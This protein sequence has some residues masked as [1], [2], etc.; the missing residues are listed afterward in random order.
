MS[1]IPYE[2]QFKHIEGGEYEFRKSLFHLCYVAL[3]ACFCLYLLSSFLVSQKGRGVCVCVPLL[4]GGPLFSFLVSIPG[5][6]AR[7][8]AS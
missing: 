5:G 3:F 6:L 1:E 8:Y 2:D 7:L 4:I